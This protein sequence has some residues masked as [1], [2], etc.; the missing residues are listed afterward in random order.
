M[1]HE[2]GSSPKGDLTLALSRIELPKLLSGMVPLELLES[3]GEVNAT[4]DKEK[5]KELLGL[6]DRLSPDFPIVTH[7]P[8]SLAK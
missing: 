7:E 8:I 2:K 5:V 6:F 3:T 1:S 4:G